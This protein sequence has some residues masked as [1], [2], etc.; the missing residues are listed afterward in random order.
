MGK[1]GTDITF[2][3]K[4]WN[5]IRLFAEKIYVTNTQ[6]VRDYGLSWQKKAADLCSSTPKKLPGPD[7]VKECTNAVREAAVIIAAQERK[8]T[9]WGNIARDKE[10]WSLFISRV[11]ECGRRA[12]DMA[13]ILTDRAEDLSDKRKKI[14][15]VTCTLRKYLEA[16]RLRQ[17]QVWDI[18]DIYDRGGRCVITSDT[19]RA[20]TGRCLKEFDSRLSSIE[21]SIRLCMQEEAAVLIEEESC[22]KAIAAAEDLIKVTIPALNQAGKVTGS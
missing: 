18:L 11:E 7:A 16:G 8:E 10:D 12:K 13:L 4:E 5:E 21:T 20:Y 15:K 17:K 19:D 3:E 9:L 1:A 2:S 14:H 6:L 22:H